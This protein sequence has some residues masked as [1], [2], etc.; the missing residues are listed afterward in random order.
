MDKAEEGKMEPVFAPKAPRPAGHYSQAIIHEGLVYISGQL[1]VNPI[2][3]EK[4]A[5]TIEEQ[6]IQALNNLE[7]ILISAGSDRYHV[8]KTTVYI[9]GIE[10]WDRVNKVYGEFFGEHKPARAVVPAMELHHGFKV[11][12]EAIAVLKSLNQK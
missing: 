4:L 7:E 12:I 10:L 3:G 8:L 6:T 11:E 5:V 2:P 9:N 1:P